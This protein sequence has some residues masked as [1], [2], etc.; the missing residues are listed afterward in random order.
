MFRG[1]N[2]IS[3]KETYP[4]AEGLFNILLTHRWGSHGWLMERRR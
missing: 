1:D 2:S 3:H 4:I